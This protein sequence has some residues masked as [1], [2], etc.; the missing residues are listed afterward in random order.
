MSRVAIIDTAIDINCINANKVEFISLCENSKQSKNHKVNHG[1]LCASILDFCTTN[2]ELVNIQIFGEN[3]NKVFCEI[4]LLEKALSLCKTLEVDIVSLSAVSSTLSDS[5][6]LYDITCQLCEHTIVVSALDNKQYIT[7]PTSYPFVIGVRNDVANMLR[8]GEIA[9]NET[10]PF[11]ANDIA[12]CNFDFLNN[13]K[14]RPSNSFAVPVVAAYFNDLLNKGFT[15]QYVN[16]IGKTLSPYSVCEESICFVPLSSGKVPIVLVLDSEVDTCRS[17]LS[18]MHEKH[19]IQA[20]AL[21]LLDCCYDLRIKTVKNANSLA[22]EISFMEH[23]YKTDVIFIICTQDSREFINQTVDVDLELNNLNNE[24]VF[25][26]YDKK[27]E[28]HPGSSIPDRI[29]EILT[30]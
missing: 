18:D 8:P 10:D 24:H 20:T 15:K 19:G 11:S 12:N 27:Q 17:L 14:K 1:T 9:F 5:K 25:M 2:Y 6:H 26:C 3:R 16:Q 7:I 29:Y 21:S 23:H 30:Q 28:V 4:D 22:N 13:L